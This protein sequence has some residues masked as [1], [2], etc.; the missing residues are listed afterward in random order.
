MKII[1]ILADGTR[2]GDISGRVVS[3]TVTSFY[4]TVDK[5]IKEDKSKCTTTK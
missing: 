1:H 4:R 5:I 3:E 2:V